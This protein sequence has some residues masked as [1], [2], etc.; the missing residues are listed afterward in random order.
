MSSVNNSSEPNPQIIINAVSGKL[1]KIY[2]VWATLRLIC[3]LPTIYLL[4]ARSYAFK[5]KRFLKVFMDMCK[6]IW[7]YHGVSVMFHGMNFFV[8]EYFSERLHEANH[9]VDEYMLSREAAAIFWVSSSHDIANIRKINNKISGYNFL[10]KHRFPR[11]TRYGVI[12]RVGNQVEWKD[13]FGNVSSV[14]A[15]LKKYQKVF[16][17]PDDE[18]IGRGCAV[19]EEAKGN[20]MLNDREIR[21]SELAKFLKKPQLIEEIVEQAEEYAAWHP[22]SLNTLR[23]ITMRNPET[24]ELY[25]ERAIFRMGTGSSHTD[26][27]CAGGIGVKV[28]SNG[29]LDKYGYF[30]DP[31]VIPVTAHPD[32]NKRFEGSEL[33]H[34]DDAVELAL[35]AHKIIR[36]INGIGWDIAFTN[37]G[38]IIIEMNPFFSIFQAQCGGVRKKVYKDYLPQ[39]IKNAN[40]WAD[41]E[42]MLKN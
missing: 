32:T 14:K 40:R 37:R 16:T 31:S 2:Y 28:F 11:T 20:I 4:W 24:R 10:R 1:K 3:K 34:Y 29:T 17:K 19:L 13:E 33:P 6:L 38:P 7:R 30:C 9:S 25:V 35:R 18:C 8:E 23:I 36:R 21:E 42:A 27:W 5:K 12:Y 26:N 39:A 22:Q 41:L 15:L